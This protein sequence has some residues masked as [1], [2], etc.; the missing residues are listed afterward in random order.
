MKTSLKSILGTVR[1][2]HYL[3]LQAM[4][5][6]ADGFHV[7]FIHPAVVSISH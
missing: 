3:N 4:N 7:V 6:G 5:V 2:E 1:R